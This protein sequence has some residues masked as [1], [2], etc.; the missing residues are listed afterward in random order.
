MPFVDG[1]QDK[2]CCAALLSIASFALAVVTT[3]VSRKASSTSSS[4]T[5]S[6]PWSTS[7]ACRSKS[8]IQQK[9][10]HPPLKRPTPQKTNTSRACHALQTPYAVLSSLLSLVI[11]S[12][13]LLSLMLRCCPYIP[14]SAFIC[15]CV[16]TC[17]SRHVHSQQLNSCMQLN[18]QLSENI[19][20]MAE[21]NAMYVW[22]HV[23]PTC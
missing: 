4:A 6:R 13:P 9:H 19:S 20:S 14:L 10:R 17:S 5:Y 3:F 18:A 8:A 22:G 11:A 15:I 7:T 2:V 23:M 16:C 1:L 12:S 21:E